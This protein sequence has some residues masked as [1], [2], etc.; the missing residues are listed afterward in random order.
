MPA[1]RQGIAKHASR[2][3]MKCSP[4]KQHLQSM[5]CRRAREMKQPI[6]LFSYNPGIRCW[7]WAKS[8]QMLWPLYLAFAISS[9][10]KY[11]HSA[12]TNLS[13]ITLCSSDSSEKRPRPPNPLFCPSP[14]FSL[15]TEDFIFKVFFFININQWRLWPNCVGCEQ[16]S[17]TGPVNKC[18]VARS[19][20]GLL[21]L[22]EREPEL[23]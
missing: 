9:K 10:G 1:H 7:S 16:Q 13:K 19:Q 4:A 21:I 6:P 12:T 22:A 8:H 3:N 17:C 5:M 23:F 2:D 11:S 14:M 20:Y 18:E 15:P